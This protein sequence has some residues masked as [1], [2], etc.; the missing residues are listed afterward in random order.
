MTNK[1]P[2]S[3]KRWHDPLLGKS[4]GK[5]KKLTAEEKKRDQEFVDAVYKAAK[6]KNKTNDEQ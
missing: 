5:G 4:V 1:K 3:D 2:Y 6:E